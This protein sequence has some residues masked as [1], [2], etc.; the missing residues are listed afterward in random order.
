[1]EVIFW[2]GVAVAGGDVLAD[3]AG[4]VTGDA[5]GTVVVLVDR[6]TWEERGDIQFIASWNVTASANSPG[7]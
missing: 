1:M 5:A 6:Q 3:D 4:D 7:K 2:L